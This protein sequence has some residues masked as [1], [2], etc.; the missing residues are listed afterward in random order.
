MERARFPGSRDKGDVARPRWQRRHEEGKEG[1][2]E[3]ARREAKSWSKAGEKKAN[4][5]GWSL[6]SRLGADADLGA[7][8]LGRFLLQAL[9][10]WG[11]RSSPTGLD[12]QGRL[13]PAKLQHQLWPSAGTTQR[14]NGVRRR[15]WPRCTE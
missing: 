8:L 3:E 11:L 6:F 10:C 15:P 13:P 7:D 1:G 5:G 4:A 2:R 12:L 14:T 9:K